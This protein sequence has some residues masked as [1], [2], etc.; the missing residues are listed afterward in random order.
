MLAVLPMEDYYVTSSLTSGSRG[1]KRAGLC[2]AEGNI[3]FIMTAEDLVTGDP[4]CLFW[5]P[6]REL[7][8]GRIQHRHIVLSIQH[9]D[10]IIHFVQ[11]SELAI[12]LYFESFGTG[13]KVGD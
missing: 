5:R 1:L 2:I 13:F 4:L 3:S 6:T 11:D 12:Q 9:H 7:A 10:A 8:G